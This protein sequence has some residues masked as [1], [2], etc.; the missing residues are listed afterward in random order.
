M[1]LEGV[2][3]TVDVRPDDRETPQKDLEQ[4]LPTRSDSN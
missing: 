4:S 1:G 2:G 3:L